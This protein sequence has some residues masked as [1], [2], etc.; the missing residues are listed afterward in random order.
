[1][2]THKCNKEAEIA[3]MQADVSYIKEKMDKLDHKL[4]GNGSPGILAEQNERISE[5]ERNMW[6]FMGGV[7]V[8]TFL[9]SLIIPKIISA[10]VG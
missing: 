6:K 4:L 10:V 2:V 8:V 1:M 5:I 9:L 3:T 7:A